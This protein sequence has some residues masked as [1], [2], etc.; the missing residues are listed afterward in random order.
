M[1]NTTTLRDRILAML[2]SLILLISCVTSLVACGNGGTNLGDIPE[3]SEIYVKDFYYCAMNENQKDNVCTNGG[4]MHVIRSPEQIREYFLTYKMYFPFSSDLSQ[5]QFDSWVKDFE[6]KYTDE[7][8]QENVLVIA[9]ITAS[10]GGDEYVVSNM[11]LGE[12]KLAV[13]FTQTQVGMTCDMN[14]WLAWFPVSIED[15][16]GCVE[17]EINKV[18]LD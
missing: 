7:F 3:D 16:E 14:A 2:I 5:P 8:F 9:Y 11:T 13:E 4:V 17:F 10:S 18:E 6:D 1:M 12:G 15:I